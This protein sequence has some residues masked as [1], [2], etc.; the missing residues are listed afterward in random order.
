M[1]FCVLL[2]AVHKCHT[3]KCC[4][5]IVDLLYVSHL[6]RDLFVQQQ[7][8]RADLQIHLCGTANLQIHLHLALEQDLALAQEHAVESSLEEATFELTRLVALDVGLVGAPTIS[9]IGYIA[10]GS[11]CSTGLGNPCRAEPDAHD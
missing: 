11:G 5:C 4:I 10:S 3:C 2:N 9:S 6:L 8:T 1:S 7:L